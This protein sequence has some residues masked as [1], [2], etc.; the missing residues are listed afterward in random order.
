V[1]VVVVRQEA[2]GPFRGGERLGRG[3]CIISIDLVFD[4]LTVRAA[5]AAFRFRFRQTFLFAS[6]KPDIAESPEKTPSR[7]DL[8]F[9]FI[10]F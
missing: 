7:S 6:E 5:R 3:T 8:T 4:G 1:T 9:N 10:L 2:N